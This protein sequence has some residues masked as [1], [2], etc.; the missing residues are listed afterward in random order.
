VSSRG[1]N[2]NTA[3]PHVLSLTYYGSGERVLADEEVVGE[4]IERRDAGNILCSETEIDPERCISLIEVGLGEGS[5]YPPIS[6]PM[7]GVVFL[8]VS[9]ARVDE[10][11][12]SIEAVV[13]VSDGTN[14]RL[15]SWRT[16]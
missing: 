4:I 1:I 9:E 12:F 16:L 14:P 2:L 6:L 13:D 10:V 8:V 11:T 7:E 3:P 5:V 15:L